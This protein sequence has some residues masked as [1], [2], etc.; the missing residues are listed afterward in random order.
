[1]SSLCE[2][3]KE[4]LEIN[5]LLNPLSQGGKYQISTNDEVYRQDNYLLFKDKKNKKEKDYN[6]KERIIYNNLPTDYI[7]QTKSNSTDIYY[8]EN[9]FEL[10]KDFDYS[11]YINLINMRINYLKSIFKTSKYSDIK[12]EIL[13]KLGKEEKGKKEEKEEKDEI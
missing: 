5:T 7:Y 11:N 3:K 10:V 6:F 2:I 8:F 1:M 13:N 9:F 4:S 12:T